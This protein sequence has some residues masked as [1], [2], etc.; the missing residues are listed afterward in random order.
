MY[1]N[2]NHNVDQLLLYSSKLAQ[3][4]AASS[5]SIHTHSTNLLADHEG[6]NLHP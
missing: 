6:K 5:I 1:F 4:P 2:Y 3:I